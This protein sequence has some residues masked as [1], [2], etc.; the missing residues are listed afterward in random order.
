MIDFGKTIFSKF[1]L[2]EKVPFS[3]EVIDSGILA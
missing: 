3:I 1:L 2:V